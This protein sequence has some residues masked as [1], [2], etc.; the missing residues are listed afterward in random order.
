MRPIETPGLIDDPLSHR[1]SKLSSAVTVA[2]L[3]VVAVLLHGLIILVLSVVNG[4]IGEHSQAHTRERL[5]VQIV[6][7][8]PPPLVQEPEPVEVPQPDAPVPTD[9]EELEKDP[10]PP[11]KKRTKEPKR[12]RKE[13]VQKEPEATTE[14][15][16]RRVVGISGE[17]TVA[18]G[19]GPAFAT[20]TTRMGETKTQAAAPKQAAKAPSGPSIG[21]GDDTGHV[22][23]VAARI[24][25]RDAV[26]TKPRRNHPTKPP[27][28]ATLKAQGIEGNVLV[29]VHIAA[30]GLVTRVTVLKGSGHHAFDDAATKAARAESYTPAK[31]DGKAV[32]FTLSY[33]YR[34]RIEDH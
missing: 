18:G 11:P 4:F 28:P 29:R 26:F 7:T 12:V 16:R 33:S 34:F 25:T 10:P 17:S 30:S 9:F 3:L 14:P 5:T 13:L 32:P 21:Q 15:E 19:K 6:D 8:P 1:T 2:R 20:G 31:R 22:Q 27:Y 24:P 23:R